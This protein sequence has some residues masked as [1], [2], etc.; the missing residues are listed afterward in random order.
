MEKAI[1]EGKILY[2]F[3]DEYRTPVWA[4]NAAEVILELIDQKRTEVWHIAGT[5]RISRYGMGLAFARKYNWPLDK[6]Q[7]VTIAEM[8]LIPPRCPDTS[9]DAIKTQQALK[10]YQLI[11]FTEGLNKYGN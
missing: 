7:K 4:E 1:Q 11:K 8:P 3:V 10:K 6:I 5:E 9:L 2:L